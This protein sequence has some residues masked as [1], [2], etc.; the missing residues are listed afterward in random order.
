LPAA[1]QKTPRLSSWIDFGDDETV[2]VH[3]GKVEI[4]Q[5]ILTAL[6]Q[7]VADELDVAVRRVQVPAATTARSHDEGYTAGSM[8]VEQTA[9]ALRV[10][11]A[12]IRALFA[13]CAGERFGVQPSEITVDDGTFTARRAEPGAPIARATYWQLSPVIDLDRDASGS[14]QPKQPH[15]WQVI[16]TSQ[17]RLDLPA[18]IAGAPAFAHDLRF[19]AMLHGRVVR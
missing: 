16:G 19:A 18:K 5:G 9:T 4:G 7:V 8:S 11:C 1:L 12:E 3:T 17:S 2:V 13:E 14:P 15:Q 10:A 6:A